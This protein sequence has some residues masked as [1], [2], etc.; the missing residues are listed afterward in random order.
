MRRRRWAPRG[1]TAIVS[2][3]YKPDRLAAL[4]ALTVSPKRQHLGLDSRVQPPTFKATPV[5]DF[6]RARL[7]QRR[8]HGIVLWAQ[9]SI[10][11]GPAIAAVQQAYPR[12]PLEEFPASAPE[13]NPTEHVWHDFTSHT[14]HSLRQELR[15]RRRRWSANTRRV[16][17]SQAKLRSC[18][19]ASKLPSPP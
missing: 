2:D 7:R 11:Q 5:A 4:A 3:K 18:I 6:L 13:L 12:L 1:P 17:R 16:R 15:E 19:L 10:P 8:G 14:A 9:S